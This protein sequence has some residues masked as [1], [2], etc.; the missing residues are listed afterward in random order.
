MHYKALVV[1]RINLQNSY[2]FLL[3][4]VRTSNTVLHVY[5]QKYLKLHQLLLTFKNVLIIDLDPIIHY[6]KI[7]PPSQLY[8]LLKYDEPTKPNQH[9]HF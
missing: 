7:P 8:E 4:D 6:R 9:L 3:E 5:L 2:Q 1:L